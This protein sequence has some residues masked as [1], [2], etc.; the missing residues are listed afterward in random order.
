M[1][2]PER[3]SKYKN[4]SLGTL[5]LSGLS[6][7]WGVMLSLISPWW[8][9]LCVALLLAGYSNEVTDRQTNQLKF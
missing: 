4:G 3:Q 2:I 8:L 5:T 6:L 9:I 1:K 7:L